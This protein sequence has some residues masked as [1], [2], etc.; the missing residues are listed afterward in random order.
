MCRTEEKI[1]SWS[2]F[3]LLI[4]F[5]WDR[6]STFDGERSRRKRTGGREGTTKEFDRLQGGWESRDYAYMLL[7][8]HVYFEGREKDVRRRSSLKSNKSREQISPRRKTSFHYMVDIFPTFFFPRS[9]RLF[10]RD[11]LRR[12]SQ[13]VAFIARFSPGD[14][15]QLCW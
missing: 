13:S 8:K 5:S 1:I 12:S 6:I 9:R 15:Q 10:V 11:F 2:T 4:T 3:F 7:V 14:N